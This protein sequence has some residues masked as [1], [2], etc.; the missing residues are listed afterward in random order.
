MNE[1]IAEANAPIGI[2][3]IQALG[4][5]ALQMQSIMQNISLKERLLFNPVDAHS[6]SSTFGFLFFFGTM[7][8]VFATI[9]LVPRLKL[10]RKW[11]LELQGTSLGLML[12]TVPYVVCFTVSMVVGL[13]LTRVIGDL[14]VLGN[15]FTLLAVIVLLGFSVALMA[16]FIGWSSANP[17]VAASRMI[18]S[19]RAVLSL[20]VPAGR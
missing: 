12:R 13:M 16:V 5:N 6:N 17:G 9:G 14:T 7:F 1:I 3:Q 10:E 2:E 20:A 19:F 8:L 4:L 11:P 15:Y 18:F